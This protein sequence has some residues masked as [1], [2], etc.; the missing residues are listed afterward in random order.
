VN[1]AVVEEIR[2]RYEVDP[3]SVAPGW[4]ELFAVEPEAAL[5]AGRLDRRAAEK[6]ARV[7]R[8]VHAYRARGHRVAQIDPLGGREDSYFPELDPAHYGLGHDDLDRPFLAGDLPGGPVQTLREILERLRATY[9]GKVGVEFTHIQDPGRKAWVQRRLEETRNTSSF[10][11]EQRLR[12]LEMLSRAELFER[13]LHTRFLGQKRFSLEGAESLI[14]LLDAVVEA[15]PAHDVR[16]YVIGMAHRGRL[17]VL[18]N[19]LGKSFETIFSEFEDVEHVEAPFGS[20]DVKYHKGFSSDRRTRSGQ[21]VHLSLTGN[22]SHLE[23]VDPVV[24]GRARAKQVAR[25]DRRGRTVVPLLIHG[26]AAFAGQGIVA[27]TLNLSRLNGYSTGGTLH[28]V[29]N[30]QIGFTTTPA[31]ARSTLYCTDVAKMIQVPI[32]HVNG[33]DPEGVVHV[34][35]MA[36]DYRQRFHEDVVIDLVCYRR[37][38]H[39]EGDEPS[40]TQP[41]LYERIR[42]Q[43]PVRKLYQEQLIEAGVLTRVEADR[44]E[45]EQND[46]LQQ[47]LQVV[48]VQPPAP[49]EPYEPGG[50]WT[51]F[52]RRAP[53]G[54]VETAL[55]VE[56]LQ[57]IAERIAAV[58]P[59]FEVHKKLEPFLERRGKAIAQDLGVDWA[60]AEALAFGSLLLEGY[61]VRLSGQDSSR[62]TFSQR[63]A[64]LV[65]QGSEAEY[66][67]LAHLSPQQGR[68]EVYDSLLS[69]A[70][71]LGFEYGYTLADPMTLTIWEA[72]FGDFANGAQVIIDQFVSS[73]AAKWGRLSGLV[74][75]LPHGYEG[76]GP[77]HSSARVERYLQLCAE[78]NLQVVNC[79]TP[80]QYFHVLRRQMRRNYRAP[81]VVL[82]PKSLLRAPR[83]VS[84]PEALAQGRFEPALGDALAE[85]EPE[86][87]RRVLLCSGKVY[88]DLVEERERRAGGVDPGRAAGPVPSEVAIVRVEQ[89]YPWEADAVAA[90]LAP[91]RRAE[92][93]VWVQ[94]EP[95]NQ[96]PWSFVRERIEP[97]LPAGLGLAYAG[98]PPMA[99]TAG[100]SMRMHKRRQAALLAQAFGEPAPSGEPAR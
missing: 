89:L 69:E 91:Y 35:Q 23:A 12:I 3:G 86:R 6:L 87:V 51:G 42:R 71:V 26:D 85:R 53:A 13:F 14:P 7:L 39:N 22:P 47:A 94:E 68:F 93:V 27:E 73:A 17:N 64:V 9:C 79:T 78:D 41:L 30:N 1:A 19:I 67:P 65:D 54:P 80:A 38:G 33:D 45:S 58:P 97:L 82:T 40:Y 31:E 75:L 63:H 72:Q 50:P 25:G 52:S 28:V 88:Y 15:G 61:S 4:A 21:R 29:V 36:L 66:A 81:L 70:A 95:S 74:M 11:R 62:G 2:A 56:R 98:R 5:G 76:Q 46:Q 48:K 90:A 100:G 83:A 92:H 96:G 20:G 32:F 43:T 99:A 44:M 60:F 84:P 55:P 18:S 49:D 10:E 16:E 59:G 34:A 77:E 24:E 37:H 8:L 57:Q